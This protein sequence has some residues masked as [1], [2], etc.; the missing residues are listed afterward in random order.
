MPIIKCKYCGKEVERDLYH[1]H[2]VKNNFCS[3]K[4]KA[5]YQNKQNNIIIKE[6][7]AILKIKNIEILIDIKNIERINKYKWYLKYDDTVKNYYI[8]TWERNNYFNRK[9]ISLH[10]FIMNTAKN[11]ECDHINRN[12]LDNREINL[13]NVTQIENLQNKGFYKNNKSG[14]KY[15][16]W[17]KVYKIYICEIKRNKKIIFTKRS[18]NLL[19]L[20]KYRDEFLKE[21]M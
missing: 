8:Y 16:Y 9:S 5:L 11:M 18:K 15:I 7:Y 4:C 17:S 3:R 21:V 1:I 2:R 13:R 10:R 14:Y 6:N 12:T 19:E 20:V